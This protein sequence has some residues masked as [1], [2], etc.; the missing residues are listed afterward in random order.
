MADIVKL[1]PEFEKA[2]ARLAVVSGTDF[3]AEEFI[4]DVWPDGDLYIDDA[5]VMKKALHG[6]G[7]GTPYKLSWM[8]KPSVLWA[9]FKLPVKATGQSTADVTHEKTKLLGGSF[10]VK[11]GN[12]V[13]IHRET[14][15]FDNGSAKELL[16]AVLGK[17]TA[18]AV[19]PRV[20]PQT[21]SQVEA[22]SATPVVAGADQCS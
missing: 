15:S 4:K 22:C 5:E 8:A 21:P 14:S 13:Y 18:E 16:A 19:T 10:V 1:R 17:S 2:G 7:D 11:D 6:G 3:G 9:M 12:V 20:D